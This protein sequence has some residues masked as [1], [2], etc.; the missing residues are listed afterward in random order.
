MYTAESFAADY[1]GVSPACFIDF[2]ALWGDSSDNIPVRSRPRNLSPSLGRP[3]AEGS[4]TD[5]PPRPTAAQGVDK[6]GEITARGL[7]QR[8]GSLQAALVR[9]RSSGHAL[10]FLHVRQ[11]GLAPHPLRRCT[12]CRMLLRALLPTSKRAR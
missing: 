11:A 10:L 2:L 7:L 1:P 8:F 5:F 9:G 6:I 4:L 3:P 12:P